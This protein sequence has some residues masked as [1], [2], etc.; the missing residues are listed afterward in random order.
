MYYRKLKWSL[1]HHSESNTLIFIINVIL[2][3]TINA[4]KVY[5]TFI[6]RI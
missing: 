5:L 6:C 1:E 4:M 2:K 3:N